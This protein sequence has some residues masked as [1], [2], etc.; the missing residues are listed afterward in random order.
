MS[1]P[2]LRNRL[3]EKLGHLRNQRTGTPSLT[4]KQRKQMKQNLETLQTPVVQEAPRPPTTD[5]RDSGKTMVYDTTRQALR[6][7]LQC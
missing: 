6:P 1:D 3:K 7:K 2:L 4:A 5:H